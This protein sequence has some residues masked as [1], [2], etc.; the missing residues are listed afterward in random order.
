MAD[1]DEDVIHV[2]VVPRLDEKAAE[3]STTVLKDKLKSGTKGAGTDIGKQV[4]AEIDQEIERNADKPATKL[5]DK[6]KSGMKG[7][8]KDVGETIGSE[9]ADEISNS[10]AKINKSIAGT[11][12]PAEF[13]G[14]LPD[15]L[16]KIDDVA[17]KIGIDISDWTSVTKEAKAPADEFSET[18]KGALGLVESMSGVFEALPGKLGASVGKAA[19]LSSEIGAVLLALQEAQPYID[20][21]D[22]KLRD[23]GGAFK[24][25]DELPSK[26]QNFQNDVGKSSRDFLYQTFG[27]N[28]TGEYDA[29][30]DPDPIINTTDME[31]NF[32]YHT[33]FMGPVPLGHAR[34][35]DG[36][37]P[38]LPL[39]Q[40]PGNK[41]AKNPYKDWYP[42]DGA[43]PEPPKDL[44]N[45]DPKDRKSVDSGPVVIDQPVIKDPK[46][47]GGSGG[48]GLGGGST[49]GPVHVIVDGFANGSGGAGFSGVGASVNTSGPGVFQLPYD[50][51]IQAQALAIN[52]G[53]SAAN[54][55]LNGQGVFKGQQGLTAEMGTVAKGQTDFGT[56]LATLQKY[57]PQAGYTGVTGQNNPKKLLADLSK[58]VEAGYG[59]VLNYDL[60]NGVRVQGVNGT[61]APNYPEGTQHYVAV[62]GVDEKGGN[63]RV[64]DPAPQ[65]KGSDYWIS[66]QNAA[67]ATAGRG[68]IFGNSGVPTG[69]IGGAGGARGMGGFS[70]GYGGGV[71]GAGQSLFGAGGGYQPGIVSPPTMPN[72]GSA[73]LPGPK[74]QQPFGTGQ[75]A[76]VSGGGLIGLAEQGIVGA[77]T[78]AGFMGAGGPAAGMAAQAGM[79]IAN[80]AIAAGTQ[81]ASII[82][83]IPLQMFGLAGGQMGAPSV[84][85]GGWGGKILQGLIGQQAN[86]PNIAGGTQPPKKP[87]DDNDPLN[88]NTNP[89]TPAGP[90]GSKDD[91]IHVKSADAPKQPPQGDMTSKMNATP[92]MAQ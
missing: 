70:Q 21:M 73:P 27:W 39:S 36:I 14:G 19:L 79:Q 75:G 67:A 40:Q 43:R 63:I 24:W 29:K 49:R 18:V 11:L 84:K 61:N 33:S 15:A 45:A 52:C 5:R 20:N 37:I 56:E 77:A 13:L 62:M 92:V 83:S 88:G 17:K 85:L 35:D 69:G 46:I 51:T 3:K 80:Q 78:A 65:G 12:S 89:S 87:G 81:A 23:M 48:S 8:G 91:P 16:G 42:R 50:R 38:G 6:L 4:N 60:V 55:V 10:H 53:P 44:S 66:A 9:I 72:L 68:Y 22:K 31:P 54:I 28:P 1:N 59:G 71:A 58:S 57:S 64:A 86:T 30:S 32:P 41:Q 2:D 25:I 47:S 26:L 76:G 7:T 90:V 74:Q 34:S 82:A